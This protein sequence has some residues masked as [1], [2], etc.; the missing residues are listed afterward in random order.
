M[1]LIWRDHLFGYLEFLSKDD[2]DIVRKG[3]KSES[4]AFGNS[5][6]KQSSYRVQ[7]FR[8]FLQVTTTRHVSSTNFATG[9]TIQ[10]L[11]YPQLDLLQLLTMFYNL[12]IRVHAQQFESPLQIAT[13]VSWKM[14]QIM[15]R[16]PFAGT[17]SAKDVSWGAYVITHPIGA[18]WGGGGVARSR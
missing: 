9:L 5:K 4:Y 17:A 6:P 14:C 11:C 2:N 15:W 7:K 3:L 13:S 10:T 12:I 16:A 18:L 1:G 8:I